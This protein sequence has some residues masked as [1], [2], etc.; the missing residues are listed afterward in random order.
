MVD[1]IILSILIPVTPERTDMV[2]PLYKE[3]QRQYTYM[4]SFHSSLG[5]IEILIDERPRFL[6]GGP[7]IGKKRES[8]IKRANGKY[9]CFV[10]ADDMVAGNYMESIVR[11]AQSDPDVI[12]FNAFAKLENYWTIIHMG[13]H[14]ENE[15]A[16]PNGFV[17]RR[18]SVVCP[19][20]SS[21]AK[22]H[23]FDDINYHEDYN[24]LA[25]VLPMCKSG[26]SINSILYEYR[27]G[28][29]SESDQI[30]KAGYV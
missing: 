13:L 10:D 7:S 12:S 25:K 22:Q 19:I 21:I 28:Q 17:C 1:K 9:S 5:D 20:R 16:R 27:H 23:D 24:W 8:L 4:K 11:A 2:M 3:L 6:S 26:H 15:E 18:L 30:I 14:F 29:H